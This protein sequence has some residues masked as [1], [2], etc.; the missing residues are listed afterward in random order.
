MSAVALIDASLEQLGI[1]SSSSAEPDTFGVFDKIEYITGFGFVACQ[2]YTTAAVGRSKAK[3]KKSEVLLFG[4]KHRCGRPIVQLVNAAAN[5]WKHSAEW[6]PFEP[7]NQEKHTVEVIRSLG[8]NPSGPYPIANML[9]AIL[10]P[11]QNLF[12]NLVP[13]IIQWRDSLPK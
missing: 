5:R 6:N 9:H 12:R 7:T 2:T 1:E 11:D 10:T 4:P 13:Y 8:V 3:R